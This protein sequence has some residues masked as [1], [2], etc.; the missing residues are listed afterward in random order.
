VKKIFEKSQ[1]PYLSIT[2]TFSVCPNHGYLAGEHF[3]CPK[4]LIEQPCEVYSRVVGYLRPVQQ[5]NKGKVSE[6]ARRKV[7]KA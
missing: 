2:P 5:W 7:F 4:C 6:Y 3:T 1:M